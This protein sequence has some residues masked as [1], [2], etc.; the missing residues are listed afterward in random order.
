MSITD[1]KIVIVFGFM[2]FMIVG[3]G[4]KPEPD[5]TQPQTTEVI[6]EGSGFSDNAGLFED[7]G[8]KG[9][10]I[11]VIPDL[12]GLDAGTILDSASMD[13][14]NIERYFMVFDIVEGD[15]VYRRINGRSYRKN[16]D[17]ELKDLVYLK[18]PHYNFNGEIQVG[19]L[20]VNR[21][22]ASD[23]VEIFKG[24]FMEKY[25]IESMFLVD[26]YWTGD[27]SAADTESMEYNNT[28][29]FNYRPVTSGS[30]L[31]NH[32]YGRAIDINPRQNPYVSYRDGQ[33]H[34]VPGNADKYIDRTSGLAYMITHDDLAYRLFKERGFD[35][36]G[37]W[38]SVKDYQHF[39]KPMK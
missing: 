12:A 4:Q 25:P 18:M 35:W 28:S 31:S 16:D 8:S 26:N 6:T 27:P 32:A 21:Q 23:T 19:E 14:E 20:I 29:A 36:G 9:G 37:D 5:Q 10:E 7:N 39:E 38:N 24:L 17:I 22:I 13:L 33:P 11:L 30:R 2:V 15:D 3:C 1:R 34:W